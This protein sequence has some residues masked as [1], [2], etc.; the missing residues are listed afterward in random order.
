MM[1]YKYSSGGN[2]IL[3]TGS[4]TGCPEGFV[5][6]VGVRHP[7]ATFTVLTVRNRTPE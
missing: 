7:L 5:V 4:S 6:F 3:T 2:V 1:W